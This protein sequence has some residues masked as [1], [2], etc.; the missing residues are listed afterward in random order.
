MIIITHKFGQLAN[1][2]FLFAH[3]VAFAIEHH[4]LICN[5]TFDEYAQFF[6]STS[7]D[8]FCRYPS[9][10]LTLPVH[11]RIRKSFYECIRSLTSLAIKAKIANSIL[12]IAHL[13]DDQECDLSNP[14]FRD[15]ATHTKVVLA[16][17][18]EFRDHSNFVKHADK[19]RAYFTPIAIHRANV[20][21]LI[22]PIRAS[23]DVLIG[24]HIRQGDYAEFLGGK[25]FY[26]V[27]QYLQIMERTEQL[28]PDQK[29]TFLICSNVQ[30]DKAQF[31]KFNC[32]FGT[33]H[34]IE[35]L[36]SLAQCDYLVGT[37][38]TYILWASYYG[39]VPLYIIEEPEGVIALDQFSKFACSAPACLDQDA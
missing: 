15:L 35:D 22:D 17:G 30:H 31:S 14:N 4:V 10:Q 38:S 25:Y 1:R 8:L 20:S 5:P 28:F 18:W 26:T 7:N 6:A 24:V 19:I 29:V 13:Q 12:S 34:L 3:F 33:Q 27:S 36:Y 32:A 16:K 37:L 2:L 9:T 11:P 23:C 21:R 39:Q